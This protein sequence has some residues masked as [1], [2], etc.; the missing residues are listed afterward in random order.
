[1]E[2][3]WEIAEAA[4]EDYNREI[5]DTKINNKVGENICI[6][7]FDISNTCIHCG[8][9]LS[10]LNISHEAEWNNYKDD[11]GNYCKNTQRGDLYVDTNPY[12]KGG[13]VSFPSNTLIGKLS[14]QMTFSHKQKTYWEICSLI[15]EGAHRLNIPVDTINDSKRMWYTYM[16]SGKL[17]R[18]SVRK[19]LIASCLYHSCI[20][21]K[22][23]IEREQ[24]ENI[25]MC[26]KKALS[27]GEKV[28]FEVINSLSCINKEINDSNSFIRYCSKL[29]LPHSV[30]YKC[31]DILVKYEI[32]LQAVTPKSATGGILAYVVKFVLKQKVP[33]K[34]VISATVDVC[35]PTI[36]KVINIIRDL[37]N[38]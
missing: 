37:E 3:L 1:M 21:N 16:E 38:N 27:K 6:H 22:V 32:N 20:K 24:I 2:S 29:N 19:G 14:L 34:T 23:P 12:S 7:D 26:S 15:E 10:N 33:T 8:L 17:T 25:F 35:T 13:T 36:N 11:S 18:A 30:A 28:L 4:L 9:I 31:N 5:L